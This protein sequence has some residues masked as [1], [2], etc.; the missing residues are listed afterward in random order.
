MG[1]VVVQQRRRRDPGGGD[2]VELGVLGAGTFLRLLL[3]V[4]R[5][6]EALWSSTRGQGG[7]WFAG[8]GESSNG[9]NS[10]EKKSGRDSGEARA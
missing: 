9:Q 7:L 4:R 10:P 3:F 2:T 8:G 1:G 5:R 6:V